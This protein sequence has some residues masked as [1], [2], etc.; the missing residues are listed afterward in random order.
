MTLIV[1][2]IQ[3]G[4]GSSAKE[5]TRRYGREVCIESSVSRWNVV[6][7]DGRREDLRKKIFLSELPK[8]AYSRGNA[9]VKL[10]AVWSTVPLF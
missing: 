3:T 9:R 8:S 7:K 6:K 1:V 2:L 10:K 4:G 5:E